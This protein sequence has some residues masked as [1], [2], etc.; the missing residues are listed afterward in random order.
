[1]CHPSLRRININLHRR[2]GFLMPDRV[3]LGAVKTEDRLV[4][5]FSPV[6]ALTSWVH[7]NGHIMLAS[8][9]DDGTIRCWDAT[10]GVPFGALLTVGPGRPIALAAWTGPNGP[11]LA[12]GQV[13]GG[14][15]LWDV[16]TGSPIGDPLT[17][18]ARP[19]RAL[20]IWTNPDGHVMLASG[21]DDQT[22]QR[23]N[24]TTGS[25]I[26]ASRTRR[27]LRRSETGWVF[28]LTAWTGP[29]GPMLASGQLDGTVQCWNATTGTEVGEVL[30]NCTGGCV[31]VRVTVPNL[32]L[33][34]VLVARTLT[35]L[36]AGTVIGA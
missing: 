19:V 35:A 9:A 22:I 4:A 6:E 3:Q 17:G 21:S 28:A 29:D 11:L 31:T 16:I 27:R 20:A 1:M 5:A 34:A 36:A 32:E 7:S 23:W 15:R 13:D 18:H 30:H 33:S 10:V 8:G 24:A 26:G 25:Q 12:S 14:I 2:W